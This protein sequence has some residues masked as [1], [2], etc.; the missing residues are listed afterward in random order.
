M[1]LR[2]RT[3][4][5]TL[6]PRIPRDASDSVSA[7]DARH[8]DLA[9]VAPKTD[10][11]GADAMLADSAHAAYDEDLLRAAGATDPD[12]SRYD[13]TEGDPGPTSAWLFDP[14]YVRK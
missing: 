8:A 7:D 2:P 9:E 11:T 10:S 3:S 6:R 4:H 13:L 14:E 5:A 1:T 12:L